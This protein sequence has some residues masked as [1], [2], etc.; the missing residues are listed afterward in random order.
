[1]LVA[2]RK[3]AHELLGIRR[4]H[5]QFRDLADSSPS[6]RSACGSRNRRATKIAQMRERRVLANAHAEHEALRLAIFR[7]QRDARC[8]ARIVRRAHDTAC[9]V[10]RE[11]R[12]P[13]RRRRR[14]IAR[15]ISVRP[16]PTRPASPTISP[17]RTVNVTSVE[18]GTPAALASARTASRSEASG[19]TGG[20]VGK[21][22]RARR[23]TIR[24]IISF[25]RHL[26]SSARVS[27]VLPSRITVM[28]S[29]ISSAALRGDAKCRRK[30]RPALLS[31]RSARRAHR[32][33]PARSAPP[34]A[35]PS[36]SRAP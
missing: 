17:A 19:A 11:S 6:S 13:S 18:T 29:A 26:G 33:S 5:A 1:M 32:R 24:R 16:A 30:R 23:P 25:L 20:N 9:P 14:A 34:S 15:T 31:L 2:A 27:I 22:R 4:A 3:I 10:D 8:D 28:R 35:R 21:L 36:R 12:P 7:D